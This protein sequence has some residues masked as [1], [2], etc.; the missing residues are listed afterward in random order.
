MRL[1]HLNALRAFEAVLRTGTIRLAAEELG[2][3]TAA[4]GQQIRGLEA[5]I[6]R[7][8][9]VRTSVGAIPTEEALRL[10]PRLT[11][12]F[13]VIAEV[14][15]ELNEDHTVNRVAVTLPESFAENWFTKRISGFYRQNSAVDLRLNASNRRIDLVADG[16]DFAIRYS[17]PPEPGLNAI[18]LF[19][20]VVLPVCTPGFR[21]RYDLSGTVKSLRRI[22]IVHLDNRTPDPNWSGWQDWCNA[23]D[24]DSDLDSGG[25]RYSEISSG[26][27][28]ALAGNGLVLCGITEAYDFIVGGSL[29]LP[30]GTEK[31]MPTGYRYRLLSVSGR[32]FSPIQKR[33]RD[34][35]IE[36][37]IDFRQS[38]SELL[39]G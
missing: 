11:T 37:A 6:G 32:R 18:D 28:A 26:L 3:T 17:P 1:A 16:F 21:D 24:I 19:G 31:R 34:W 38:V 20:D 13:S 35:V 25:V 22:P 39:E 7:N 10:K 5:T 30:F 14:L 27:Q 8:L 4:V 33:F 12:G 9:F 2:V 23:F 15:S 29:V 36:L